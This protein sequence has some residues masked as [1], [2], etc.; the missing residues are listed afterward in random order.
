MAD[1]PGDLLMTVGRTV[2]D[3]MT[4]LAEGQGPRWMGIALLI[5]LS[6]LLVLALLLFFGGLLEVR[7][8]YGGLEVLIDG[9]NALC[10][11]YISSKSS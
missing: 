2:W 4:E 9:T 5:L 1:W 3:F 10:I 6:M 8:R 7:L 11:P